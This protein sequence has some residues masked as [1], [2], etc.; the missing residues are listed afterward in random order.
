MSELWYSNVLRREENF[1]VEHKKLYGTTKTKGRS[2]Q[3][4]VIVALQSS[5]GL[6]QIPP[7]LSQKED[8]GRAAKGTIEEQKAA[9][10]SQQ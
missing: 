7:S 9:F 3:S 2:Y 5:S 10:A 4:L 1:R 8:R 6:W